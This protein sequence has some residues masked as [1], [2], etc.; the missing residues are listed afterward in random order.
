VRITYDDLV[1]EGWIFGG[2]LAT[3]TPTPTATP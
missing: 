3:V 2:L 1:I